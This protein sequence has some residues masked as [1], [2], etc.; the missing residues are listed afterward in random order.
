MLQTRYNLA[1][2]YPE[3]GGGE[4]KV[5]TAG[6]IPAEI[7]IKQLLQAGEHLM[8]ARAEQYDWPD[9]VLSESVPIPFGRRK[10]TDLAEASQEGLK[11]TARLQEQMRR[12]A[13]IENRREMDEKPAG[14]EEKPD[15]NT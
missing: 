12:R 4:S 5:E 10:D 2:R 14:K 6:Y 11:L 8:E 13:A 9:G 3:A 1:K 7:R 15:G